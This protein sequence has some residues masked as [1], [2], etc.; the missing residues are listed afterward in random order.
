VALG[1]LLYISGSESVFIQTKSR[2][3]IISKVGASQLIS[4]LLLKE[5][6]REEVV[7][8]NWFKIKY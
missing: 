8:A 1:K 4:M 5:F 2:D 6:S 3:Q 7:A